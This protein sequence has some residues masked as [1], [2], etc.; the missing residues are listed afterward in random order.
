MSVKQEKN[1][2]EYTGNGITTQFSFSFRAFTVQDIQVMI[3]G[4]LMPS[5]DVTYSVDLYE[6]GQNGGLVSFYH[7]GTGAP[8]APP[9]GAQI[10]IYL[11]LEY[12]QPYDLSAGFTPQIVE[13][14]VDRVVKLLQLREFGQGGPGGGS[15]YVPVS[16]GTF[17]GMVTF[18]GG[19]LADTFMT[20]IHSTGKFREFAVGISSDGD[21]AGLVSK[22]SQGNY[23]AVLACQD[24]GSGGQKTVL[25][26]LVECDT[27]PTTDNSIVTLK[28]LREHGGGGGG[29]G[30]Y[31]P[32]S[33]GE[34]KG[35][36]RFAGGLM[37]WNYMTC[38][39]DNADGY[40]DEFAVGI[41]PDGTYCGLV[42]QQRADGVQRAI[43]EA[44]GKRTVLPGVV[45]G[46]QDPATDMSFITKKWA[47]EN[48]AGGGG[49]DYVPKTGGT[50]SGMVTFE[51]GLLAKDF[52]TCYHEGTD[53]FK[54]FAVGISSDGTIAGMA[55]KKQDDT[56]RAFIY[57][58]NT[59]DKTILVGLVE[60]D[61]EPTT[62]MS[63]VTK[64]WAIDN[65]GGGEGTDYVPKTGGTFSGEVIFSAGLQS[66]N[67]MT[68][69][70]E[71]DTGF[72]EFAVGISS[73]GSIAGMSVKKQDDTERAFIYAQDDKTLI[74]GV[75]EGDQAPTTDMSF[76][77]KKWAEENLG[78][79]DGGTY[80]P[81]T[82]GEFTGEV[83][84]S[85]GLLAKDYMTCYSES[86]GYYKEFAV[87]ISGDGSIAG[88]SVRTQDDVDHTFVYAQGGKTILG[89]VVECEQAP[90][91]DMSVVTKKWA[92]DNLGG[93]GGGNYV[94]VTGGQFT[95]QVDFAAGLI[96]RDYMTCYNNTTGHFSQF[97][98]G[99]SSDGNVSGLTAKRRSDG[100]E[101]AIIMA[102]SE[103]KTVLSGWV[104]CD[105]DPTTANSV[106]TRGWV[107]R[108]YVPVGG[109]TFTGP[110]T[111]NGAITAYGYFDA[112]LN[113]GTY[114]EMAIGIATS[115][116]FGIS[117]KND[118]GSTFS[119]L[120]CAPDGS[121]E[122]PWDPWNPMGVCT[123]N[124]A[125][126]HYAKLLKK[127]ENL[128][129]R[130]N[131]LSSR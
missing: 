70:H 56:E 106:A 34:F 16:G 51:G 121:I 75:V 58:D 79:G 25:G 126:S 120:S 89:G 93:G 110:I 99:I 32:V 81:K 54:E 124:Y 125:D 11:A 53:G 12:S 78:G 95:G 6:G 21:Y 101:R 30:D 123:K 8:Y 105:Q 130:I 31:V 57:A 102:T 100:Y 24:D 35:M 87:G 20:C 42:V 83:K 80:V 98:V 23:A 45:E 37:S 85:G 103:N 38:Y 119:I 17:T 90:T 67:Y 96:S 115:G 117:L 84:F 61:T 66:K 18:Q 68:C 71:G 91:T 76:V 22:D 82:G 88:M 40:F 7:S 15:D 43:I 63:L 72:K 64:K 27:E 62:D 46:D 39:N 74:P 3:D 108:N 92:E 29:D 122:V 50:F 118:G 13:S 1:Y 26:G 60:C 55:I 109:G 127:I 111:S 128:E 73:D 107:E 97:A 33:G 59:Q 65:L 9:N 48:L 116:Y 28:Y 36:V 94:P 112:K 131:E 104:E 44:I 19:L 129:V 14:M 86:G 69:Y 52:M 4:V 114:R 41:S 2:V 49:G 10:K 5:G 47:I 113:T 77:T